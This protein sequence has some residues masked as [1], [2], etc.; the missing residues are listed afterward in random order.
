[1][2]GPRWI[3]ATNY[4]LAACAPLGVAGAADD[5]DENEALVRVVT[6]WDGGCS[7][8]SV[9]SLDNMIDAWYDELTY[10][11]DWTRD[12]FYKN[13]TIVDSDFTDSSLVGFGNDGANDRP[14]DDDACMIG[15]H[16]KDANGE[17]WYGVVRV[18]ESG[19][20]N[21]F[22]GQAHML[23][24]DDL[25][26]LHWV[27]CES[28]NEESWWPEWSESFD[29]LHQI[30]GWHGLAWSSTSY[31][32]RY[33]DFAD[34]AFDIGIADSW[35]DNLYDP[36]HW[37]E[38]WQEYDHCPVA[39]CVGETEDDLDTRIGREHYDN[40]YSDL[41]AGDIVWDGT[42]YIDGCDPKSEDP[43]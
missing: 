38:A 8:S 20:G 41:A 9:S 22:A 3:R 28:M 26:F 7:G 33:E 15:F 23:F 19:S 42:L 14:D 2:R 6:Q 11:H 34:D 5:G 24:N 40:V 37:Y 36:A 29:G 31:N 39:R 1:M 32:D 30:D 35:I 18:D 21:C 25:E 10:D 16:G 43:L 13:G 4:L 17:R 12:G 27:S